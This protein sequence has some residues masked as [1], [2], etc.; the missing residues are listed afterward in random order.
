M[1]IEL[2]DFVLS[3]KLSVKIAEVECEFTVM[4]D[5]ELTDSAKLKKIT[6]ISIKK[7]SI[8]LPYQVIGD[9]EIFYPYVYKFVID[10]IE[11]DTRFEEFAK[12]AVKAATSEE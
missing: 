1:Y 10:E 3:K 11:N 9:D 4:V 8:N 5:C 2:Q 6:L 7:P 12:D